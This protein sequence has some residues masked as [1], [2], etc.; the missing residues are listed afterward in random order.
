[1]TATAVI[2]RPRGR[3]RRPRAGSPRA[4]RAVS[5]GSA[6]ERRRVAGGDRDAAA[7]PDRRPAQ[8]RTAGDRQRRGQPHEQ[9]DAPGRR[10]QQDP[11]P[12]L[13]REERI[14]L[15]LGLPG[16]QP[17]RD[18]PAHLLR[19][20]RR[21]VRDR[22]V[23]AHRTAQAGRDVVD[24]LLER[25]RPR[26]AAN[27]DDHERRDHDHRGRAEREPGPPA[28]PASPA[29][30]ARRRSRPPRRSSRRS[31]VRSTGTRPR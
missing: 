25:R 11:V 3:A 26:R 6:V 30:R 7:A 8:P 31:A 15:R 27:R 20:L 2:S 5:L 17:A 21:R 29:G 19:E 12:V 22:Q 14:D 1:M 10:R 4:G 24:A 23:L 16:L 28:A 18:V 9:P 13:R